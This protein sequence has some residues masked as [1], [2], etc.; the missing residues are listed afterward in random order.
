MSSTTLSSNDRPWALITGASEGLGAEFARQIA[1]R[2]THNIIITARSE[3]K[4][5]AL[6]KQLN[7]YVE[8][9]VITADLSAAGS[10]EKLNEQTK[11]YD[12][13]LFVNNAGIA[14]GGNFESMDFPALQRLMAVNMVTFTELFY[15]LL[16]RVKQQH[17]RLEEQQ[18]Q[19]KHS[20]SGI[21]NLSSTAAY[22]P[23]PSMAVYAASKVSCKE[24]KKD[25]DHR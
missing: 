7:E 16:P 1:Q 11:Q 18:K 17:K 24:E 14:E 20:L 8:C 4:L 12:L 10:A 25:V 21:I 22:M 5:Q 15:L 2:Q 9:K 6:A 23:I 13:A 19:S 3:A